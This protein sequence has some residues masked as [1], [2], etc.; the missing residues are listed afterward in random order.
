MIKSIQKALDILALLSDCKGIP[1]RFNEITQKTGINKSTCAHVLETLLEEG[2]IE[3]VSRSKGYVLGPATFCLTRYGNYEEDLVTICKPVMRHIHTKLNET[4]ILAVMKNY[5]KYIVYHL[6]RDFHT[7]NETF[8]ISEDNLYGTA[9]GRVLISNM[10]DTELYKTYIKNGPP[11]VEDWPEEDLSTYDKFRNKVSKLQNN[12]ML[13]ITRY[14]PEYKLHVISY[15]CPIFKNSMCV[16]AIGVPVKCPES[17][18]HMFSEYDKKISHMLK[19]ATEEINR[20]LN[21]VDA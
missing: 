7:F 14:H 3:N 17:E 15:A 21:F 11:S 6:D 13:K 19:V 1:M 10:R 18:Y 20:R 4:V 12:K 2:F 16:G 8:S 9:S 5:S